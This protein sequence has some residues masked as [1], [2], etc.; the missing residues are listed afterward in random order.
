[1]GLPAVFDLAPDVER[2]QIM[3]ENNTKQK[4]GSIHR[5]HR[6]RFRERYIKTG[7]DGFEDHEALELLLY[8]AIARQ[9]VNPL[10]HKLLDHFGS[11]HLVLQ[12]PVE[13]LKRVEGIGENAAV[14]INLVLSLCRKCE[15]SR[16]KSIKVINSTEKA[17]NFLIPHLSVWRDEVVYILCLDSKYKVLGCKLLFEGTVN[18]ASVHIRK[19]AETAIAYNAVNIMLAHN[20]LSGI[21][22]P[23]KEDIETTRRVSQALGAMDIKLID[24]VIIVGDEYV[25]MADLGLL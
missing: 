25:S 2:Q 20:H 3:P 9:D 10:A 7:L 1:M 18:S 17:G 14:L 5:G 22:N 23:S 13:E 4:I 24:H 12:A 21:K 8:F 15:I 6:Q 16:I 19:I 11:F